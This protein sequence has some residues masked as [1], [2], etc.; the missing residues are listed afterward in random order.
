M[1]ERSLKL[2]PSDIPATDDCSKDSLAS[3]TIFP[4][5]GPV[6]AMHGETA[7]G[8]HDGGCDMRFRL[9]RMLHPYEYWSL[10]MQEAYSD[11][12]VIST[13]SQCSPQTTRPCIPVF[14]LATMG[15]LWELATRKAR[16]TR[17]ALYA[18]SGKSPPD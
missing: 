1:D 15:R 18:L 13:A 3:L 16:S 12:T 17:R 4:T 7:V 9:A 8:W 6:S 10:P 5:R 2:A 14:L 11:R